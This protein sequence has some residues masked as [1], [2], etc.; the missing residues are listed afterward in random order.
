[1][2][3]YDKRMAIFERDGWEC[4]RCGKPATHLAHRIAQTKSNIAKFGKHRIHHPYN[5]VSVC[6]LACNAS[7][8]IGNKPIKSMLL[9]DAIGNGIYTTSESIS[10][11]LQS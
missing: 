7:Y 8:N 10:M 11:L 4:Q 1:M 6:G 9:I 5:I 2:T 3:D